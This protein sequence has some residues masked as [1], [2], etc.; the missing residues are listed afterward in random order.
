[1]SIFK[2]IVSKRFAHHISNR[3]YCVEL[4]DT[5]NTTHNLCIISLLFTERDIRNVNK[6]IE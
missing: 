5:S 4:P 1:M 3:A 2:D 6:Y